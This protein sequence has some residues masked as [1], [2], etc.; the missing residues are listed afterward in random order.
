MTE[1]GRPDTELNNVIGSRIK[2]AR[3]SLNMTLKWLAG[4]LGV[5]Y[6]QLQK[7]ES[8]KNRVS[9]A[10]LW[11]IAEALN[12]PMDFFFLDDEALVAVAD[13]LQTFFRFVTIGKEADKTA[14][15]HVIERLAPPAM[16]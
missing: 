1:I 16:K 12:C 3:E 14:V 4:E 5:S 7:Y 2:L 10:R 6:Q 8:G 13:D 15:T 9:A 11:R